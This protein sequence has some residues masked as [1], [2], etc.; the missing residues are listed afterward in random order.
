MSH[1]DNNKDVS[2]LWQ[3]SPGMRVNVEFMYLV[4]TGES[5]IRQLRSLC[6]VFQALFNSL[7][8]WFKPD[9]GSECVVAVWTVRC[10]QATSFLILFIILTHRGIVL[11]GLSLFPGW[12]QNK[13]VT[14]KKQR[15]EAFAA[16]ISQA[17]NQTFSDLFIF[18][19]QK[20]HQSTIAASIM[21]KSVMPDSNILWH[22]DLQR[23][24]Q[25][26]VEEQVC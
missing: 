19:L 14:C 4:F 15:P 10:M 5:Y 7:V 13:Y 17:S 8:H 6:D 11:H 3:L 12:K 9:S 1:K 23:Q 18:D 26:T 2:Y 16:E 24:H 20:Q 25:W 22:C 21:L